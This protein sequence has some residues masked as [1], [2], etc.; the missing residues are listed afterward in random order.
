M[1]WKTTRYKPEEG[2]LRR[3]NKFAFLPTNCGFY[4][5]WLE[6]YESKQRYEKVVVFD[7]SGPQPQ[8]KWV[9]YERNLLELY[10]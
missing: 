10:P 5:I 2:H 1:K 9:E 7:D 3:V 6:F 4:T 8:M